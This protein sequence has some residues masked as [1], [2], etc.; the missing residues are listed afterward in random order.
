MRFSEIV[1]LYLQHLTDAKNASPKTRENYTL[2]LGRA[3]EYFGDPMIETIKPLHLLQR[4]TDLKKNK[5]S[6]RTINYHLVALRALFKFCKRN[7]IACMDYDKIDLA[8]LDPREP[9]FLTDNEVQKI[10]N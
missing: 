1:D 5:L 8:K 4:R 10:L 3:I 7:D 9:S 2:W 6:T